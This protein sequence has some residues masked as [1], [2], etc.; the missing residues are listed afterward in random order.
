V[1]DTNSVASRIGLHH[2]HIDL[3]KSDDDVGLFE[4]PPDC[5][6]KFRAKPDFDPQQPVPVVTYFTFSPESP[7]EFAATGE[8]R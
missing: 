3:W 7:L 8:L 6:V 5:L 2:V 4:G 1:S